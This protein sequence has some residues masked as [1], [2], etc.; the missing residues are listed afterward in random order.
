[1]KLTS[2]AFSH[3]RSIPAKYTCD[4]AD[5]SPPLQVDEVPDT[6]QTLALVVDDPDAPGGTFD[7]WLL[8]NLPP[9]TDELPE[10]IEQTEKVDKLAGALQGRNDFGQPGYRGPCP[11]GGEHRY[12]FKLYALSETLD[13]SAGSKKSELQG[14][15]E[16]KILAQTELVG[17][18]S[19]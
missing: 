15:M 9:G 14:V 1:M 7:H 6:A 13:L 4:G 5:V 16:G 19:R 12:R 17:K 18:Y 11:P 2:S 3:G 8:W 10:G